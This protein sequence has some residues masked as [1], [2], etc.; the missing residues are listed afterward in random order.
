MNTETKVRE[1]HLKTSN[2]AY[3]QTAQEIYTRA[4]NAGKTDAIKEFVQKVK[5]DIDR[6]PRKVGHIPIADVDIILSYRMKEALGNE[7]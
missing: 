2:R 7:G 4:Y 3:G 5:D 6:L 1:Y